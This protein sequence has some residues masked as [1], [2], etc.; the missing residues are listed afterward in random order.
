MG[1]AR[2]DVVR[3][4]SSGRSSAAE[5]GSAKAEAPGSAPGARSAP[6]PRP[7]GWNGG[8]GVSCASL[9]LVCFGWPSDTR[10]QTT[11]DLMSDGVGLDLSADIAI[12]YFS[13]APGQEQAE[14]A[15]YAALVRKV[16]PGYQ[17][18]GVSTHRFGSPR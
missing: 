15:A 13:G 14:R 2:R 18:R 5:R 6:P 8:R 16:V 12:T 10:R 7:I 4:V 17:A 11:R 9:Y 3:R 1:I